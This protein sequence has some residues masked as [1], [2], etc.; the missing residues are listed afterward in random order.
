MPADAS[1]SAV[2][3]G[4]RV[5]VAATVCLCVSEWLH[6][7]Q[8]ALSVYT[9]HLVM[10]LFPISSFQKGFE[11]L[12]GR[13]AGVVYGW[14]LIALFLD[15]PLLYLTLMFVG[16]V[17]ACYVYLSGR[18]AY[19]ALMAAIFIGV[20]AYFGL[21]SP[22]VA[23][24][25]GWYVIIQVAL[26]EVVA[27]LV[28]FITGA[29][30]TLVIQVTG[31]PLLP[32]QP[33]WFNT[34]AMLSTGQVVTLFVT[35]WLDLPVLP[36]MITAVMLGVTPGGPQVR[37]MRARQRAAG[38]VFGGGYALGAMILLS[39]LPFFALLAALTFLAMFISAYLAK[40]SQKYSYIFLQTGLVIPMV[41]IG[42]SGEI[43]LIDKAAQRWV[44]VWVGVFIGG[45]VSLLWPHAEIV[46]APPP[47]AESAQRR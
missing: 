16:Q 36:T 44:G 13:G 33:S 47:P 31:Q 30:R 25:Y 10:V 45:L 27:I 3:L 23:W 35:Q 26:G 4:L 9:T 41:L 38:A 17:I 37:W 7:E 20:V 15:V 21:T 34:A 19:A 6:L 32:L 40:A 42:A 2:S 14:L 8:T 11:R 29:E 1:A 22:V 46:A 39:A 24:S 28:N 5:A 43:G 18:L 12:M